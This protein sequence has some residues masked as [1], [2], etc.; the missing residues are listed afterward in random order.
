MSPGLSR[1]AA[2]RALPLGYPLRHSLYGK[3]FH[4]LTAGQL[5]A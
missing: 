3:D 5:V 2:R 1:K 4:Q